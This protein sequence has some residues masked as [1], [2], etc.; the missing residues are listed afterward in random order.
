M[1]AISI[2][3]MLLYFF[4]VKQNHWLMLYY[5]DRETIFFLISNVMVVLGMVTIDHAIALEQYRL[6]SSGS[7]ESSMKSFKSWTRAS[8]SY[9]MGEKV[10]LNV[11]FLDGLHT[12]VKNLS[13]KS[14][15]MYLGS[16][17]FQDGLRIDLICL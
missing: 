10:Y 2:L 12:A 8:R 7:S 9:L 17:M 11:E 6:F 14:Q 3:S 15:S 5:Y 4:D 16:A 13:K 1:E